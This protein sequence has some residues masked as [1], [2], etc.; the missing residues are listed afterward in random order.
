MKPNIIIRLTAAYWDAQ[1]RKDDGSLVRFDFRTMDKK[2][3]STFHRELMNAFR[4]V[5]VYGIY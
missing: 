5:R 1:V 2:E 3:R 4:T